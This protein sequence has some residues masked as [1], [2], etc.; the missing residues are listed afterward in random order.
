[1]TDPNKTAEEKK[2]PVPFPESNDPDHAVQED[3]IVA[4][5]TAGQ[6]SDPSF[7]Q[8]FPWQKVLGI[9]AG[10]LALVLAVIFWSGLFSR[11]PD[12]T[13]LHPP[14][15]VLLPVPG[16]QELRLNDFLIPL[17][18]GGSHTGIAFSLKI[19]SRDA[20]FIDMTTQDKVWLRAHIYDT[21]LNQ[22]Q[23]EIEPPSLDMV[24][25]WAARTIKQIFPG[26]SIDEV[27]VDNFS[28]L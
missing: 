7:R 23:K 6:E 16:K 26:R 15:R 2:D 19:R 4:D 17:A 12:Q 8:R 11:S 24:T 9:G 5:P 20:E 25:Y 27:V 3:D 10:L 13:S 1:M 28:V 18:P 14:G 21:L 22:M